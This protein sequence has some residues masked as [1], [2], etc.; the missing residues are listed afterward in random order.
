ME[1]TMAIGLAWVFGIVPVAMWLLLRWNDLWYGLS[2]K[3]RCSDTG[4]K[5]P[6]GYMGVPFLGEM[7]SFLWYFKVLRR[8]D[9]FID[10]KQHKYG[11]GLGIYKTHLFGSPSIICCSPSFTKFIYQTEANFTMDWPTMDIL[12]HHSSM[13]AQG[14]SHIRLKNFL[15]RAVNQPVALRR[16][17]T[18]VQP[19]VA[20]ALRSW[21]EKGT[22]IGYTEA[23]KVTLENI[24]KLLA[25]IEPGTVLETLDKMIAGMFKGI[26]SHPINFPGTDY[27]YGVQCRKK[28]TWIFREELERRKKNQVEG[29]NITNDVMDGLMTFKDDEGEQLD[30]MEVI[31][32]IIGLLFGGYEST[33]IVLTWALY[34]L[35]KCPHVLRK[36]REEHM[37][38]GKNKDGEFITSDEISKL[39]YTSKEPAKPGTFQAFGGGSRICAGNMLAR[40]QIAIFI[41]HLAT[42]Y[43]WE[44]VNPNAG[45]TYLPHPKPA[46]G[47][48]INISRL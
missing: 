24:G 45:V 3:R 39:K 35:A 41:H 33:T 31:D 36:L 32:N 25:N 48:E 21:A 19:R 5:L 12:G 37:P 4:T 10:S 34:Y 43:K 18:M 27:H 11:K 2:V 9:D 29:T 46:D 26:R 1:V 47:L 40:L 28:A 6:P 38:F 16:I 15:T 20:S 42:G 13:N 22:I 30:D 17:A 14:T 44:L 8:P 23:K 7:L